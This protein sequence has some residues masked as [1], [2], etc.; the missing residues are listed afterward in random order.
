MMTSGV[1]VFLLYQIFNFKIEENDLFNKGKS[2]I[3]W[4][5]IYLPSRF[6]S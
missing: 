4:A 3:E 5:M 6:F 2:I 1:S